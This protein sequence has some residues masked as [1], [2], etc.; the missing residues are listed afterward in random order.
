MAIPIALTGTDMI[1]Q[2]RTGT[3][4]TLAFGIT[5]LQRIVVPGERDYAQLAKP[6][7]RRG[8]W[9]TPTRELASQV[10]ADLTTAS[11][12]RHARVL[13][14]YGGVGY[15]TQ[16]NALARGRGCRRRHPGRL[17]DLAD[18]G[19]LDLE[20]HQGAGARRGRRDARPGLPARRRAHPGED[21]GAAPD[22]AVLG[23][24]AGGDRH[25]GPPPPAAPGQHPGRVRRR[26][27]HRADDGAVRLPGPRP[28][29]ARG[30]RPHPAG[31]EPQPG[32][33][34]LPDQAVGPATGRRPRGARFRG[35]LDPRRPQ[36]GR[37]GEGAE[38]VP[39]RHDRRPGRHRRG[40]PRD[41]RRGRHPRDQLRV[42]RGREDLRPPDR[43]DRPGRR[44]WHRGHL[45]RLGRPDA[46][47]GDQQHARSAVRAAGGDLLHLSAPLPR[48]GHR[49]GAKG[50]I[51]PPRPKRRRAGPR[52][53]RPRGASGR[54]DR[55]ARSERPAGPTAGATGCAERPGADSE[56][57][58]VAEP[59]TPRLGDRAESAPHR[60]AVGDGW[61]DRGAHRPPT[62][63]SSR[64]SAGA[65]SRR[66]ARSPSSSSRLAEQ[67]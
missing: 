45:R 18:R 25:P 61:P 23:H 42:P 38:A 24:H 13:T 50:R 16:L 28:G 30:R 44:V 7:A 11:T 51:V 6:G 31:R 67:A 12:R 65:A 21:A 17:L 8:W 49:P 63:S 58:P 62:A 37:P 66:R 46:L 1:G 41:R 14:I 36:P 60:G 39:R 10:S 27:D 2:A 55:P 54:V 64:A 43:P 34:L 53:A 29:Q 15:D 52:R 59:A 56:R 33:D 22:D 26:R 47:E 5:M 9:S 32:D 20:P 3:G 4:K 19:A 35:R 57:A 40:G 48:P